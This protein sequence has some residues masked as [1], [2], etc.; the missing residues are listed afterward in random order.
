MSQQLA[1]ATKLRQDNPDFRGKPFMVIMP[2]GKFKHA[3]DIDAAAKA[4][5]G[6]P[7]LHIGLNG[8]GQVVFH[9]N[10]KV[11]ASLAY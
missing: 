6:N 3:A 2:D 5:K 7:V 1:T 10:A 9:A 11:L 4:L 8:Y